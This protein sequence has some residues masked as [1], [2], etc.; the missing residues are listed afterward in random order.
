MN[1][2][3]VG[4]SPLASIVATRLSGSHTAHRAG[5]DITDLKTFLRDSQVL[6]LCASTPEEARTLLQGPQGLLAGLS[7]GQ[8]LVDQTPAD[9]DFAQEVAQAVQATGARYVEAPAHCERMAGWPDAA[10]VLCAGAEEATA[11]VLDLL[12]ALGA[13][14]VT[15]GEVGSAQAA[16]LVVAVVAASNRLVTFESAAMGH[17]NGLTVADMGHILTRCSGY[18]SATARVLPAIAG[19]T[20][21][22]DVS[23]GS[24][25]KDL[26]RAT[27]LAMST[28][29]PMLLG[30]LVASVLQDAAIEWGDEA[31][32]D[33]TFG[34]F[35]HATRLTTS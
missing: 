12:D 21:A 26:R 16:R 24:V 5:S 2:T 9:P 7:S 15:T 35:E 19:G 13:R 28:G 3:V 4:S 30:N 18:S 25:V 8:T 27:N 1:I 23:L 22:A 17:R 20:P 31:G 14:R 11:G 6:F 34:L 33:V 10:V 32:L 29:A